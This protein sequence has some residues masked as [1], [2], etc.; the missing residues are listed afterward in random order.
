MQSI[1]MTPASKRRL[2]QCTEVFLEN[3]KSTPAVTDCHQCEYFIQD[4]GY[5]EHFNSQPPESFR[6]AD[7]EQWVEQI[8]F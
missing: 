5:C 2:I 6:L 7:C 4:T 1:P 3:L 8:P